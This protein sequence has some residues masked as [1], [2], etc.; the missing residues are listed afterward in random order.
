VQVQ[1]QFQISISHVWILLR[2]FQMR[3]FKQST[4]TYGLKALA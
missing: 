2:Q 4:V 3:S 1:F